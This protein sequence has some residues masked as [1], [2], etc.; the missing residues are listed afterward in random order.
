MKIVLN[1]SVPTVKKSHSIS[2]P[3]ISL[4]ELHRSVIPLVFSYFLRRGLVISVSV[5][6]GIYSPVSGYGL[7]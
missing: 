5:G 7:L 1:N 2:F 6:F 4:I 3:R